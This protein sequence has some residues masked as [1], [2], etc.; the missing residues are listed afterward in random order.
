MPVL[1]ERL[2]ITEMKIF[3]Q[4]SLFLHLP[5][6]TVCYSLCIILLM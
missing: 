4:S 5:A 6:V 1:S 2:N 3:V